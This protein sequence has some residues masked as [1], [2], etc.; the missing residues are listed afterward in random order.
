MRTRPMCPPH[1]WALASW[2][3]KLGWQHVGFQG[4]SSLLADQA[5]ECLRCVGCQ[6][7]PSPGVCRLALGRLGFGHI[8]LDAAPPLQWQ[9]D[10]A[11]HVVEEGF[12]VPGCLPCC[13][14]EE[15]VAHQVGPDCLARRRSQELLGDALPR[16]LEGPRHGGHELLPLSALVLLDVEQLKLGPLDYIRTS[17]LAK[18]SSHPCCTSLYGVALSPL[19]SCM[20]VRLRGLG[21]FLSLATHW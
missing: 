10:A 17:C 16:N 6:P 18:L 19:G 12:E 3:S 9:P 15:L 5:Q 11:G 13:C 21:F 8:R 14:L 1:V 2:P 7:H 20:C 4:P